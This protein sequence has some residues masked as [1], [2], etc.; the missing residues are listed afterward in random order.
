MKTF[1]Y[2]RTQVVLENGR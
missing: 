1:C 2:Q